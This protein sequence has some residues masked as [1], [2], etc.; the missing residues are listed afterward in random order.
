[1]KEVRREIVNNCPCCGMGET[2]RSFFDWNK[3]LYQ[4][5]KNCYSIYQNPRIVFEYE[6][7]YWGEVIDPDGKKR[8]LK[9]EKDD[10]I[11][12]W[13]G[14]IGNYINGLQ[15]GKVLDVGAGLGFLLSYINSDWE[16][17][18]LEI[19]KYA[20]DFIKDKY[21][22]ISV[23]QGVLEDTNYGEDQFDVIVFYHVIEHLNDPQKELHLLFKM[24]KRNGVLIVG[25]P[26]IGS[27]AARLFR[28]NFRLYGPG[29]VC[30]FN[31]DSLNKIIKNTGFQVFRREYP[32]WNTDYANIKNIMRMFR[33][34]QI[35]PPFYGSLMTYYAKK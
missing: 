5:C 3:I 19:S 23:Q 4:V 17:Y 14:D 33:L 29:H 28:G 7:N 13:Y 26:N 6:E 2:I 21:S 18:A 10:K 16:K 20:V 25:T 30:L 32:F 34:N 31:P 22:D 9:S 1:L 12:N 24:L 27:L 8:D 15:A 35:S 11:K